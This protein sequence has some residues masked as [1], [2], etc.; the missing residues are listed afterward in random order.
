MKDFSK[1]IRACALRNAVEHEGKAAAGNVLTPLFIFGLKK[2]QIKEVMP[3]INEI[4]KEVNSLSLDEQKKE[5]EK[6]KGIFIEK[7]K[8]SEDELP[9]LENAGKKGV[10]MRLAPSPSGPMHVGH[11]A[12]GMPSAIYVKKYGG[13][14]YIRIED[15]NPENIDPEAY[16]MIPEEAEWLFGEIYPMIQSDRMD[17]YYKYA[18]EFIR[19]KA[20]YV[21]VCDNEKF[22][23][24]IEKSKPCP[25]RKLDVKENQAR[26][27]KM[28]DKNGYKEG[29]AVLRFKSD[30]KNP[31]PAMRDFPLARINEAEHPRQGT[32]YRVWPLMNLAVTADDI[33]TGV[34][35]AIRAKDHKDN[36]L[37]QEMMMRVLDK[38][39]PVTY[40][41]G[42]YNF[43]D[44]EISCSKTKAK[45]N[46]GIYTGWG[47]IRL[48]FIAALRKRGFKPGAFE[49]M[50][51][52]RGISEV[53]KV[54][55]QK[56]YFELLGNFNREIIGKDFT[57]ASF[58]SQ[59]KKGK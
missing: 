34:T 15:T 32:K 50:A 55:T 37:R 58:A 14:F 19:K 47:D 39:A 46:A 5:L 18:E 29:E 27:K 44:L 51:L 20:A 49:K 28:L 2:E 23:E 4:V 42:R 11:A 33:E 53:D 1:E 40:F 13:K 12:T 54:M 59:K 3:R 7:E 38:K 52:Q 9:E 17:I 31:N 24:L 48:P 41:L 6:V 21:C 43:T 30:L 8:R 16:E 22:K 25:C 26:W 45:I 35:H 36:A 57:R 56:D 10:V